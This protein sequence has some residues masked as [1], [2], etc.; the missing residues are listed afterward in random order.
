MLV[1]KMVRWS[2]LKPDPFR[3]LPQLCSAIIPMRYKK[4]SRRLAPYA[5]SIPANHSSLS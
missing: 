4:R 1:G 2:I 3:L 5:E